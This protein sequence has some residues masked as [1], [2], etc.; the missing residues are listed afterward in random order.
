MR[1]FDYTGVL[2]LFPPFILI[3][4]IKFFE[5]FFAGRRIFFISERLGKS[6][7][8]FRLYKFSTMDSWS[9]EEFDI[10]LQAHPDS[11][12]EWQ[13]DKKLKTDPRI[14]GPGR[15]LRRFSLDELPQILNIL[16]GEMSLI[17]PRPIVESEDEAYGKYSTQLHSILPGLTG[18]W[19]VSGRNLTTYHRRIAINLYY[20]KHR[21]WKL[22]LWILYKTA[23]AVLSGKG[24]F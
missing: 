7:K 4:L 6:R 14:T 15:F 21:S 10:W 9:P 13:A 20:V 17:G 2:L 23:G 18:L 12:Q 19:Q 22:D 3:L 1:F 8:K 11:R 24:A 16:R 5:R